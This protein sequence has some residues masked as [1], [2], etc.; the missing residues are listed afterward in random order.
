MAGSETTNSLALAMN[1]GETGIKGREPVGKVSVTH[2][3]AFMATD[4][5][6][7]GS[8]MNS[9]TGVTDRARN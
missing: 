4:S 6:V 9:F 3:H 8:I 2:E 1:R 7:H 5:A